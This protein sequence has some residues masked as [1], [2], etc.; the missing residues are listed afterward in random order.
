MTPKSAHH[1]SDRS[2][3][4]PPPDR[5]SEDVFPLVYDELRRL[6]Q[7]KL[8]KLS[9]GNT[10]QP[11]ALVHE[12]YL[13]L[14]SKA[15]ADWTNPQHFFFVAA[16]AMHDILV[17]HARQKASIKRGGGRSRV[18]LENFTVAYETRPDEMLALAEALSALQQHDARKHQLVMLRFFAGCTSE[19][20]AVAMGL[21]P[22][23]VNRDWN[24]A[25]AWLHKRL[26]G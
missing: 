5:I 7:A 11:T 20:A 23:T 4:G 21:S 16:R 17:E 14:L 24:Y 9:P 26:S 18:D 19:Q 2:L 13:R 22:Q 1:G 15:P 3:G 10:L 8:A 25:R 6:A 12:A